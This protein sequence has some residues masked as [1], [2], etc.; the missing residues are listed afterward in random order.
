MISRPTRCELH[1][2]P[3]KGVVVKGLL[4]VVVESQPGHHAIFDKEL[5]ASSCIGLVSTV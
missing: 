1:E 5:A 2:D 4:D 3:L